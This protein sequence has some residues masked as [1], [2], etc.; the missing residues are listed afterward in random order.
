MGVV[1]CALSSLSRDSHLSNYCVGLAD[2]RRPFSA[3][4]I[5]LSL[6]TGP[7]GSIKNL[8]TSTNSRGSP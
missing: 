2:R 1:A 5:L 3:R 8:P 7:V 6:E 4:R